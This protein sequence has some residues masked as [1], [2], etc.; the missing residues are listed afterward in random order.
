METVLLD[1]RERDKAVLPISSLNLIS[2]QEEALL[3]KWG[4]IDELFEQYPCVHQLFEAQVEKAPHSIALS[5][6]GEPLTY[7][8]LN[9]RAEVLAN[10]IA[11]IGIEPNQVVVILAERSLELVTALLGI[12]KAGGCYLALEPNTPKSRL[13]YIL[14]DASP[15][16]ILTQDRFLDCIREV[17]IP[18]LSLDN[19]ETFQYTNQRTKVP[20]EP[21]QLA[22][23]SYTSGSTGSPKGVCVPH[24]AVSRLVY[25][26]NFLT[27]SSSDVFLL[28]SPVAF[29]ASTLEIWAPLANGGRLAIYDPAPVTLDHLAKTI[30]AEG[31]TTLWLTAGLFHLMVDSHIEAFADVKHVLAGGDVLSRIHLERLLTVHPHLTF[32]N[33]YGPTEN[34]TFTTCWTTNQM[35]HEGSIPIGSPINGTRVAILDANLQ[36]V[37]VGVQGELYVLGAGLARCYLNNPAETAQKFIPAPFTSNPEERMYKTGDLAR[38]RDDGTIEFLGRADYQVK[39]YGYRVELGE[40]E[41][42]ILQH[43]V[44]KEAVVVAQL[45]PSGGKRLLSYIVPD[46]TKVKSAEWIV[47]LQAFLKEHLPPYMVPWAIIPIEEIPLNANGKVDRFKLPSET[48]VPRRL[49]TAYTPPR[50]QT[51]TYLAQLWGEVLAVEPI[52]IHDNFFLIGGNSLTLAEM[53]LQIQRQFGIEVPSRVLYQK[54]TIAELA[55]FIIESSSSD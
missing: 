28:L 43:E 6:Q 26:S 21:D 14:E 44:I 10:R 51:E 18:K 33:G 36:L 4:R 29:D 42:T 20:I 22:Y 13:S 8:Q 31:V 17:E 23:I 48:R 53:T 49:N 37:P 12:L 34:T 24:K 35:V 55:S 47:E 46:K 1:V 5:F 19:E 11:E 30:Q 54:P 38:W 3:K 41:A 39:I 15:K 7:Q 9:E 40:V 2:K 16:L 45:D 50:N 25:Q 27:V 52:G 32:T